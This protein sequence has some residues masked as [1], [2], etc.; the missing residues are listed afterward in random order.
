M[1]R[2]CTL[3]ATATM[4]LGL[5]ALPAHAQTDFA[6]C[7]PDMPACDAT[8]TR[9]CYRPFNPV[10]TVKPIFIPMDRCH[11]AL[12]DKTTFGVPAPSEAWCSDP[13][14]V[15][16]VGQRDPGMFVA[17]GLVYRMMQAGIPVYWA[18]NPTKDPPALTTNETRAGQSYNDRDID[19]WILSS[20]ATPPQAGSS[21]TSC[22]GSCTPP[23]LRLNS[24]TL[25]P[26]SGSYTKQEF[27][28]RGGGFIIAAEDRAR[29]EQLWKRTGEFASH[30]GDS[31]WDF[32]TVE[33]YEIQ[34]NAKL[35][36]LDY[37]TA[38]PGY[39]QFNSGGSA[40][41]AVTINYRAPRLARQNPAAVSTSWLQTAQL[42]EPA[43]YPLCLTGTFDP[44]TAVYC[45]VTDQ[46]IQYGALE[47][48]AFH[49]AWL[50]NWGDGAS[51]TGADDLE[52]YQLQSFMR[53]GG[54]VMFM[55]KA[56]GTAESCDG[57]EPLG[58]RNDGLSMNPNAAQEGYI[59][60]H[61]QNLFTQWGDIPTEFAAGAVG[62]WAY[63][64]DGA[65][66]MS[67]S[68]GY[69]A[70]STLVRL[71][72]E[73]V[74]AAGNN[75]CT[76]HKTAN[77]CDIYANSMTAD[78]VDVAAYARYEGN[79]DHG[80]VF[81]MSGRNVDQSSNASHLRM[82]LNS[83][84]ALPFTTNATGE[85]AREVSRSAPV[86]ATVDGTETQFSGTFEVYDPR[87]PVT[88][89]SG[90]ADDAT[91]V[92][93]HTPG[94]LRAIDVSNITTTNTDFTDLSVIYDAAEK[95]PPVVAS[96]CPTPFSNCRTVFTHTSD[97][98]TGSGGTVPRVYFDT[99]NASALQSLLS[100]SLTLAETKTLISRVLAGQPDGSGGYEP[101]LGGID[102]S[103]MA[104]IEPSSLRGED[105]PTIIYVGGLDGMLHA[106]CAEAKMYCGA[107]GQ[108]LWA[109]IPRTQLP[110]LRHNT[111]RIDGSPKVI[112]VY[113]DP[114]SGSNEWRTM[115]VFPTGHGEVGVAGREPMVLALDVTHPNDPQIRW[116]KVRSGT[117]TY[118]FGVGLGVAMG[119]ARVSG[120]LQP[121][122]FI[123]TNNGGTGGAGIYLAAVNTKTGAIV[124]DQGYDHRAP[125]DNSNPGVPASAIPGGLSA[126]DIDVRG[127][128]T[129]LVVPTLTG[130]IYLL[131][132]AGDGSGNAKVVGNQPLFEFSDDFHPIGSAPSIYRDRT[133]GKLYAA[134]VS[135]GYADPVSTSWSP[136][137]VQ[138]YVLSVEIDQNFSTRA[139]E[140]S[141]IPSPI[142]L[143]IKL[144][145][146]E[147]A[148]ASAVVVGNELFVVTDRRD[149]NAAGF[150]LANSDSGFLRRVDLGTRSQVGAKVTIN[151]GASS[152]DV[153]RNTGTAFTGAGK[154]TKKIL[155]PSFNSEGDPAELRFQ[156]TKGRKLW[157]SM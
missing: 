38:G 73:D 122:T 46:D 101:R 110:L 72:T 107:K 33:L 23:V 37:R 32:S 97:A 67:T 79:A 7:E 105:R 8:R 115:L 21:L 52:S 83:F 94:H 124:W 76:A 10:G 36:Y 130:E 77:T 149:V 53:S 35:V 138:Q 14:P 19:F 139:T 102:R 116:A 155:T 114:G 31:N 108:E 136:F 69:Q 18:I 118:D 24:S 121:L 59:I 54:S 96:G 132:A 150:G 106:F 87:K 65:D 120:T 58:V 133:N 16:K 152:L 112:D 142:G 131:D 80:V 44:P 109:F 125:R 3:L 86:V 99:S 62:K 156:S 34:N 28:A 134:F 50:D 104:V 98:Q 148:F 43:K 146:G 85:I 66:G 45:D 82:V 29:F 4:V 5:R 144:D 47:N 15:N 41:V 6:S 55:G 88:S 26:V 151:S 126:I 12:V 2:T 11:Q 70:N 119:P 147:R 127:N 153:N 39:T 49:W 103:S 56:V 84:I 57:R 78:R 40:P 61:P 13:S 141:S 30:S 129:H 25:N 81:Y 75:M 95:F 68:S 128:I 93:P 111:Q 157:L 64:N 60:R 117:K 140:T 71:V 74:S 17:Y 48:G 9:C 145:Q 137:N 154:S 20:G 63:Y 42:L 1:K 92:F 135:G 123:Y 89:Y 51:C 27:P 100:S 143:R 113:M 22:S 90:T 91:F